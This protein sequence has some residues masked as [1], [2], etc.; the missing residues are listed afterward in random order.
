MLDR[1]GLSIKNQWCDDDNRV[2]I[3]YTQEE[4]MEHLNCNTQKVVK[5]YKE[6]D[7]IGLIERRNQGQGKPTWI[8]V[9]NFISHELNDG[10]IIKNSQTCEN[11]KSR[12]M[13]ITT[14]DL[15]KSKVKNCENQNSR[16]VEITSADLRKSQV[17]NYENHKSRLAKIES[18]EL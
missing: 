9:K 1:M 16:L 18:Q 14:Q 4:S 2:Y 13:K 5:L 3:I 12:T 7:D 15:R 17:K 10:N 6:L 11:H 8:Y